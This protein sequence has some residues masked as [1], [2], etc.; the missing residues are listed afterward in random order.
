MNKCSLQ[1]EFTICVCMIPVPESFGSG[2]SLLL[3]GLTGSLLR[4]ATV[5]NSNE[6]VSEDRH[7]KGRNCRT[8][9]LFSYTEYIERSARSASPFDEGSI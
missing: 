6:R 9:E 3:F 4:L 1:P 5:S 7:S 8:G 2:N